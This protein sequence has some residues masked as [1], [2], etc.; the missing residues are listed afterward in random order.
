MRKTLRHVM[1]HMLRVK[2]LRKVKLC[3]ERK[4][5]RHVMAPILRVKA[6][7]LIPAL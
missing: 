3:S 4:T 2:A 7:K 6:L 1:A 5:L